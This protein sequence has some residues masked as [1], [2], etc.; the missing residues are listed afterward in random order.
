MGCDNFSVLQG[1]ALHQIY[2]SETEDS[3]GDQLCWWWRWETEPLYVFWSLQE[4]AVVNVVSCKCSDTSVG[5]E[6]DRL[7]MLTSFV[8]WEQ[9]SRSALWLHLSMAQIPALL[10]RRMSSVKA[11]ALPWASLSLFSALSQCV[12][13]AHSCPSV[14]S[15]PLLGCCEGWMTPPPVNAAQIP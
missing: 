14:Q 4:G 11:V 5:E 9:Y 6:A 15:C 8:L 3:K 13:E 10:C 7:C 2:F 12:F 1:S